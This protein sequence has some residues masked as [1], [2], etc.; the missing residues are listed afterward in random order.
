MWVCSDVHNCCFG[1]P[2]SV[3]MIYIALEHYII[4]RASNPRCISTFFGNLKCIIFLLVELYALCELPIEAYMVLIYTNVI[5]IQSDC[6]DTVAFEDSLHLSRILM[7]YLQQSVVA[8]GE[9]GRRTPLSC[10]D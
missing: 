1:C 7:P 10:C 2:D 4:Q 5:A 8:L 3:G 6:C 9:A